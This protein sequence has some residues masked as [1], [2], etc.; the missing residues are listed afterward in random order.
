M[1]GNLYHLFIK[2]LSLLKVDLN[3]LLLATSNCWFV[4]KAMIQIPLL[5]PEVPSCLD[6]SPCGGVVR[7]EKTA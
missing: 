1:Y 7:E 4:S 2:K 3:V 5:F 6:A